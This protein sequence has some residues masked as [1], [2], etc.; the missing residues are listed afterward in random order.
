MSSEETA[1]SPLSTRYTMVNVENPGFLFNTAC[2]N[3]PFHNT[4]LTT[5]ILHRT[6]S[7]S[8]LG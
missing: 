5:C 3:L 4:M 6:Y 7:V 1:S 2:T 8:V